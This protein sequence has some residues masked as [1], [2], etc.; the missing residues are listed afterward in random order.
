[1]DLNYIERWLADATVNYQ[2][3]RPAVG[4][5][6]IIT[7]FF[8]MGIHRKCVKKWSAVLTDFIKNL[9]IY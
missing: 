6:L 5:G 2:D 9:A 1:M 7:V 4:L 8:A 3:G